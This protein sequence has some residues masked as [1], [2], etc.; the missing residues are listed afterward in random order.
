MCTHGADGRLAR[1][2]GIRGGQVADRGTRIGQLIGPYGGG[3]VLLVCLLRGDLRGDGL[4]PRVVVCARRGGRIVGAVRTGG[5]A[6][7]ERAATCR[8][9]DELSLTPGTMTV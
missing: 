7:E 1:Q 8:S 6:A 9:G 4:A 2:I 5:P 3:D